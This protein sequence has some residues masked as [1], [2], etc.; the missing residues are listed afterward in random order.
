MAF[1]KMQRLFST[2]LA[3]A[4]LVGL[5]LFGASTASATTGW[6]T[7]TSPLTTSG[8]YRAIQQPTVVGIPNG[9]ILAMAV[10]GGPTFALN[11]YLSEDGGN[12]WTTPVVITSA[13]H[14]FQ[15]SLTVL[16]NGVIVAYWVENSGTNGTDV[17]RFASSADN[18]ISWSSPST[19][20][21]A[22]NAQLD[23][24]QPSATPYGASGIAIL[25]S[26][27]NGTNNLAML[28]TSQ[29]LISWSTARTVSPTGED[30]LLG[31][32]AVNAAGDIATLWASLSGNNY[33]VKAAGSGNW[34]N[35]QTVSSNARNNPPSPNLLSLANG[36]F[37][38]SWIDLTDT[39]N[40]TLKIATSTTT[41]AGAS[42]SA[43][44]PISGALTMASDLSITK[45]SDNTLLAVWSSSSSGYQFIH[46]NKGSADNS[47]W[48]NPID[49]NTQSQSPLAYILPKVATNSDGS[50]MV[51]YRDC[52]GSPDNVYTAYSSNNGASWGTPS[53]LSPL[54]AGYPGQSLSIA[55]LDAT[56]Y[57]ITW[58]NVSGSTNQKFVRTYNWSAPVTPPAPTPA[59]A[60]ANTGMNS[61]LLGAGVLGISFMG[62]GVSILLRRKA[63]HRA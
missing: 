29:D 10:S 54:I 1:L 12:T 11:T 43:T 49:V 7:N 59:P 61:V 42:W 35:I 23:S 62:I 24:F 41:N 2:S 28:K 19:V 3:M 37:S 55:P 57:A 20:S 39:V 25:W 46:S 56:G 17:I 60:L 26:Q 53:L 9:N 14:I 18:G 27:S 6:N 33:Q 48:G 30:A 52:C 38:A 40:N 63:T 22:G 51:V 32:V 47:T 31:S 13:T 34:S 44:M 45:T 15:E 50:A 58:L 21:T 16:N 36:S 4:A 8:T 5:T